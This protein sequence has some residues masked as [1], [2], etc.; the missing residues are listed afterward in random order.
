MFW[1]HRQI[2]LKLK[3]PTKCRCSLVPP[4]IHTKINSSLKKILYVII[5][6]P[7]ITLPV[8][9]YPRKMK[10]CVH[11]KICTCM[12]T[13]VLSAN[14][15]KTRNK[16]EVST[17]TMVKNKL[18]GNHAMGYYPTI[19]RTEYWYIQ[20]E[21]QKIV[22]REKS[23]SQEVIYYVIPFIDHPWKEK[24]Y[25]KGEQLSDAKGGGAERS[26]CMIMKG[27]SESPSGDGSSA[28]GL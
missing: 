1:N 8:G 5:I 16:T 19:K 20:V 15:E 21:F 22:L 10:T 26:S 9:I 12:F 11:I 23:Q 14:G 27:Q 2:Q 4:F 25:R 17:G 18:W 3:L 24:N 7:T 6:W 28:S 13:A